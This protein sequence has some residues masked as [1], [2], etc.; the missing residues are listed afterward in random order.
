MRFHAAGATNKGKEDPPF[1]VR[2]LCT[3]SKKE[4]K[5]MMAGAILMRTDTNLD[6]ISST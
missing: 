5:A 1:P 6:R 2:Y 4:S 3:V